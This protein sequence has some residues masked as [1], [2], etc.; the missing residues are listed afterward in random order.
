M[1]KPKNDT[2]KKPEP[3]PV[4]A[5]PVPDVPIPTAAVIAQLRAA[6]SIEEAV[7][8]LAP[9]V[10][11]R[12]KAN[13]RY[14]VLEATTPLPQKRGACVTVYATAVRHDGPF[15]AEDIAAALPETKSAR[16]WTR[17]L[18]KD[19]FFRTVDAK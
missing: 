3:K 1:T 5:T 16:Y 17:R 7:K 13:A 4:I 18:A 14:E 10:K 19:G 11:A 6:S 8:I 12:P 2:S 9:E 15:T